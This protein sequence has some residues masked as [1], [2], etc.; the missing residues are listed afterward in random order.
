M[1]ITPNIILLDVVKERFEFP[2]LK[3]VALEQ[4]KY[5]EPE[6][7]IIEAKASGLPLIQEL[8]QLGIPVINFTPSRG[9]DKV[10]RVHAVAPLFESG[11][12]WAPKERW[13]E[14]MIE[15]CA[16]FPHAEHDDLVDSMSQ[17]L[18]RFR[19]GNFVE[20]RDDYAEEPVDHGAQPE[21]Y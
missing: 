13:A 8:R 6:S 1:K 20:L 12:V 11:A 14:E 18:L 2:E 17:A 19:K 16:M 9:N 21:Y 5:W 4:Y 3:K 7:V 10:S 15:E